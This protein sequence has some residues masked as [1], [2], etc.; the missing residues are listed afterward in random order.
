[1]S[2]ADATIAT[3]CHAEPAAPRRATLAGIAGNVMEWY[4]FAVYGY[5]APIIGRQFFPSEDP[6]ASLVAAFGVFAAGFLMRP[7]GGLVF[8]HIGDKVGRKAALTLSVLAMAI[9]TFLIGALPGYALLGAWA[10]VFLVVLRMIQGL[11]VGGEYTTSVVFLVESA[12]AG[13]RGRA[14]SWS[15]VGAVAGTLMGSAV[16]AAIS[17]M[18]SVEAIEHW[19]WRVPFLLGLGVGLAGLYIRKHI[20]EPQSIPKSDVAKGSPVLEA[21]RTEWRAMVQISALNVLNAVGFYMAFVYV[22]TYLEK[23]ARLPISEALD[24]NTINMVILLGVLPLAG[25]LSD[26]IGRR[27]V[28]MASALAGVVFA[29]PLFWLIDHPEPLLAFLGQF[30]FALIIGGFCGVIPVTMVE[31]FPAR[32]RCSAISIGYN[33]CLGVIGGTTPLVATWLI[34]STGIALSPAYYM[35]VAAAISLATVMTLPHAGASSLAVQNVRQ[36]Q[37]EA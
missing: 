19:A 36:P 29:W 27:P 31:A 30:G 23:V 18:F 26:R 16:G 13:Q 32:L 20:P 21:F 24:I 17:T 33:L 15:T 37:F 22:V 12:P 34:D 6:A 1:M 4:D 10:A 5:F 8:G 11:S 25:S 3:A 14:G 7:I 9:P 28:L 35:M 2:T